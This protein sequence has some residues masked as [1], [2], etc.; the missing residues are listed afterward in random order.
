MRTE[1]RRYARSAIVILF[2]ICCLEPS[3]GLAKDDFRSWAD[4]SGKNK[5]K[6]KFVKL[7]ETVVTLEKEDG[8][9]VEIE[10]K[11]LS[12][13]DQKFVAEA[14]KAS[15]DNPFKSK[16]DDPFKPKSKGKTPKGNSKSSMKGSKES[17]GDSDSPDL[18]KVDLSS[19][20]H[21]AL[22][23]PTEKWSVDVPKAGSLQESGKM[24]PVLIPKKNDFFEKL[25]GMELSRGDKKSAVV[26]YLLEKQEA[27]TTRIVLCDFS[28]GKASTAA[29]ANGKMMPMALH[30]D[31]KQVLM[32]REEFGWGKHDR[33]EV[34][35]P[36]ETKVSKTLAWCPYD[37]E[38]DGNRDVT[39]ARFISPTKLVTCNNPGKVVVWK[40]PD[41]EPICQFLTV[42][43]S[44]P[45]LSPDRKLIAYA[46]DK[47]IGL[48]DTEKNEVVAQQEAPA[49]MINPLLAFSP[50]MTRLACV[51]ATQPA[52]IWDLATGDLERSISCEGILANGIDFPDDNFLLIG[53]RYVID[54]ENQLKLWTYDGAEHVRCANGA[55]FFALT[56]GDKP[57][58]VVNT[59]IPHPAAKELL[60]KTLSD[61]ELFILRAGTKVRIDVNGIPDVTQRERVIKGLTKQL[62]GNKCTVGQ[63][64]TID[65]VA[66]AEGPKETELIARH[67]GTYKFKE[68]TTRVKFVYKGQPVW[69]SSQSNRPH[70]MVM[71]KKGENMETHLRGLEHPNY[72][73]F[74]RG[75]L[76][77]FLQK[78]AAGQGPNR[79]LTLGQS[80]V[81]VNG[82]R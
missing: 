57:G 49:K 18:M 36:K 77:K 46:T 55:T 20:E 41:I 67:S 58:A 39:W 16:G 17:D 8:E 72:E 38:K 65:L 37:D 11:K 53:N 22:A 75:Q 31:G 40:Y 26:G 63:D 19:A 74:E 42:N 69:E 61:P 78:P 3:T 14:M 60:K 66:T 33:L 56:D 28:T 52:L 71:L 35:I 48:F 29:V 13:A 50:S 2:C 76:P 62:E 27:G 30:D 64:G 7:D 47:D 12:T 9:E 81:T 45:A 54:L 4:S 32:R 82:M 59:Q 79:S 68:F 23:S 15:E 24:K 73:F 43:G 10:L 51:S 34:W 70:F 6:A 21:I 1:F 80:K 25:T 5:I 44:I